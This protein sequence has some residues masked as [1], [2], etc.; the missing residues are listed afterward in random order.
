MASASTVRHE[1][2]AKLK[3][4]IPSALTPAP[5]I[6]CQKIRVGISSVDELLQGG[7]PV[8]AITEMIGPESSGR[9]SLAFSFLSQ[10]TQQGKVCAWI[11]VSDSLHPES[12]AAAG[13]DLAHLLWIRCG[14]LRQRTSSPKPW[15]R[16]DQALRS[17]D[18]LLQAGG[19]SS[20]V[21]DLGSIAPEYASRVPLAIWFRYRSAAERS[22]V[23]FILL[24]QHPC[25][26]SSAELVLKLHQANASSHETTV[27]SGMHYRI[28]LVRDR[29]AQSNV[30]PLRKPPQS[31]H[32]A[33]WHSRSPWAGCR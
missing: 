12:A 19:F 15:S 1:V 16:L 25:A 3:G 31:E 24:T 22:Q 6:A 7:L 4:R 21:L 18:L 8:G 14:T 13:I 20:I 33:A 9:T 2:E 10:V 30:V 5:R 11:D 17:A 28:E 27:F 26:K 29:S 32:T 23:S